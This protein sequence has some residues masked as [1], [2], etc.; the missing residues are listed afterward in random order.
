MASVFSAFVATLLLLL[1]LPESSIVRL[2]EIWY[3]PAFVSSILLFAIV[4]MGYLHEQR[5]RT[6]VEVKISDKLESL[7]E[8]IGKLFEAQ[9][10][11]F[12]GIE[13]HLRNIYVAMEKRGGYVPGED[14]QQFLV[15]R[16]GR[17]DADA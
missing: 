12:D 8:S 16:R 1:N 11:R 9:E 13:E 7:L 6:E 10:R 17:R 2:K 15:A 3:I 4:W 14:T 5:A